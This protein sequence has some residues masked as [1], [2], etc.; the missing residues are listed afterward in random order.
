MA[1]YNFEEE[2]LHPIGR[3]RNDSWSLSPSPMVLG[4][5]PF[6]KRKVLQCSYGALDQYGECIFRT[7]SFSEPG[8]STVRLFQW[9]SPCEAQSCV[10]V[11][12]EMRGLLESWLGS[13]RQ[14]P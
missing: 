2:E 5:S 6:I 12:F 10:Q 8:N 7:L 4:Y 13:P 1:L 11:K 9:N 3:L 14:A